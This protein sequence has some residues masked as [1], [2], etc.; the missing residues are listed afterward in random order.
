MFIVVQSYAFESLDKLKLHAHVEWGREKAKGEGIWI[1][2]S[3]LNR[4]WSST[5]PAKMRPVDISEAL[6]KV[7]RMPELIGYA[8]AW[9]MPS[10]NP[11]SIPPGTPP[12]TG[13][14]PT[15]ER[16]EAATNARL[17]AKV[18]RMEAK[19]RGLGTLSDAL[20]AFSTNGVHKDG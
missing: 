20:P 12:S 18:K 19:E 15:F 14:V 1:R 6:C 16:S 9:V 10:D 7:W 11:V 13:M 5:I 2:K 17:A 4:P 3:E 8:R